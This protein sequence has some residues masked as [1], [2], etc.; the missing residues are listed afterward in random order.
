MISYLVDWG[1]GFVGGYTK[2]FDQQFNTS[3]L[4]VFDDLKS[5]GTEN[6]KIITP[7]ELN[8]LR[9]FIKPTMNKCFGISKEEEKNNE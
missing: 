5:C 6:L 9:G 1:N 2:D 7:S 8:E 3:K 4:T